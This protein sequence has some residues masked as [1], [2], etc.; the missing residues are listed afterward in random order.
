[1]KSINTC[2]Y[3]YA[4]T[5][6]HKPTHVCTPT[7]RNICACVCTNVQRKTCQRNKSRRLETLLNEMGFQSLSKLCLRVRMAKTVWKTIPGRRTNLWEWSLTKYSGTRMRNS[8]NACI[9]RGMKI[10]RGSVQME[11]F[12]E[13]LW[14][15]ACEYIEAKCGNFVLYLCLIGSHYNDW[16]M[17]WTW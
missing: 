8:G 13:V 3:I 11:N 7:H 12:R 5:Y 14:S 9:G 15:S 1:M 17:G 10:S 4:H 2:T 16:R 6:M